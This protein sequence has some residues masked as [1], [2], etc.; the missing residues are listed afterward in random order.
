M[1]V[2]LW[3][4]PRGTVLRVARMGALAALCAVV[5]SSAAT[6]SLSSQRAGG[7]YV[8]P[9]APGASPFPGCPAY[10]VIGSRG[11]G[12]DNPAPGDQPDPGPLGMGL[13]D[14]YFA[15]TLGGRLSG[16]EN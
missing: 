2:V 9:P 7:A 5:A 4:D 1:A 15:K 16:V 6:A 8:Q 12:E 13:P 10:G 3:V 14:F 11:S